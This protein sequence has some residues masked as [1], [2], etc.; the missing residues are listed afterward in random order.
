MKHDYQ[1][2]KLTLGK[3]CSLLMR[4]LILERL[5]QFK[6]VLEFQNEELIRLAQRTS[7]TKCEIQNNRIYKREPERCENYSF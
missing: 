2:Y 1:V 4:V 6:T 5:A 3:N 7:I